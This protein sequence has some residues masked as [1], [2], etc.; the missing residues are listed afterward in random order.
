MTSRRRAQRREALRGPQ[1]LQL[2][3]KTLR[4]MR[5]GLA[6]RNHFL[7]QRWLSC[8][9]ERLNAARLAEDGRL[10]RAA[11]ERATT[12]EVEAQRLDTELSTA[13]L[14]A[15]EARRQFRI[16]R[17]AL[18][19]LEIRSQEA[20]HDRSLRAW[21][22]EKKTEVAAA[23]RSKTACEGRESE[24]LRA[25]KAGEQ[26]RRNA[27]Q[28]ERRAGADLRRTRL[29]EDG[30]LL[31]QASSLK[32]T[33]GV[34]R[35]LPGGP[36]QY[37]LSP[38]KR[39]KEFVL[40]AVEAD[41]LALQHAGTPLRADKDVALAAV[42]SDSMALKWASE[43]LRR[44]DDVCGAALRKH[45][46]DV[47]QRARGRGRGSQRDDGHSREGHEFG[48]ARS[49]GK[50]GGASSAAE[51]PTGES[52]AL[53]AAAEGESARPPHG[54]SGE[55]PSHKRSRHVMASPRRVDGVRAHA[56]LEVFWKRQRWRTRE[57]RGR[58][59]DLKRW[60]KEAL[61]DSSFQAALDDLVTTAPTQEDSSSSGLSAIPGTGWRKCLREYLGSRA[62]S[63]M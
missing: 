1:T 58:H 47:A 39:N 15:S 63:W 18:T 7:S 46:A 37:M 29:V 23:F 19:S 4:A 27:T 33:S 26:S 34:A 52:V 61:L 6:P 62:P 59:E 44:D 42:R 50:S 22:E 8:L 60:F 55:Q 30:H 43:S 24:A 53:P 41:G 54:A 10:G 56:Q 28:A 5:K 51:P 40:A 45:A 35:D 49:R 25:K 21:V 3:P 16:H 48:G 11:R 57:Q 9:R 31:R 32:K 12:A 2:P 13:M 20:P 38:H 36:M 17:T 14:L